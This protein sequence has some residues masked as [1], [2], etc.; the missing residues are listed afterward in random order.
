[1]ISPYRMP[2]EL[3]THLLTPHKRWATTVTMRAQVAVSSLVPN[4]NPEPIHGAELDEGPAANGHPPQ[5][6]EERPTAP[7]LSVGPKRRGR[8]RKNATP[9]QTATV[10]TP[11]QAEALQ[12]LYAK[13]GKLAILAAREGKDVAS[14]AHELRELL[15]AYDQLLGR[16]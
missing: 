16:L 1:L 4:P 5:M 6:P 13:V 15:T 8:P 14:F 9:V 2:L 11:E 10:P 3:V 7:T 12:P